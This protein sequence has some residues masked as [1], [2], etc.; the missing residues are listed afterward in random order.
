MAEQLSPTDTL[1]EAFE[2][3]RKSSGKTRCFY[4][5]LL[6]R[7]AV[8]ALHAEGSLASVASTAGISLQTLRN[9][10]AS[11]PPL[12]RRLTIAPRRE[13]AAVD[14]VAGEVRNLPDSETMDERF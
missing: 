10:A 6:R 7:R 8:E 14:D 5:S 4:P 13:A 2:N 12:P 11:M 1:C 9:W 3:C